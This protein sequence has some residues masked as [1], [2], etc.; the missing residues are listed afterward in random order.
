[1]K[2][3]VKFE[4]FK[5]STKSWEKMCA[6]AAE[7]ANATGPERIINISMSEDHGKGVVVVWYRGEA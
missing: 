5:S 3:A 1:M 7:F 2:Y 4:L 6:A